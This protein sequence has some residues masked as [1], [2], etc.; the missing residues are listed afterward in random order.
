[1]ENKPVLVDNWVCTQPHGGTQPKIGA[2]TVACPVPMGAIWIHV[3]DDDG[4]DVPGISAIAVKTEKVTKAGFA[5]WD[6]LPADTYEVQ[7]VK[8]SEDFLPLAVDTAEN[9]QVRRG[10]ITSVQFMLERALQMKVIVKVG[11]KPASIEDIQVDVTGKYPTDKQDGKTVKDVGAT[12]SKLHK[13]SY[14]AT[15]TLNE[16][17]K[18][19]YWID[20]DATKPCEVA[21]RKPN[22]VVFTLQLIVV[23]K[24]SFHVQEKIAG[25]FEEL[26]GARVKLKEPDVEKSTALQ[27]TKAIAEFEVKVASR[28]PKTTVEVVSL[29]PDDKDEDVYEVISLVTV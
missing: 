2:A 5:S 10:E 24:V 18:K 26:A 8:L 4:E 28:E 11:D 7:V 19:K 17:Q 9:V 6:P 13:G 14:T 12:F 21:Y 20:G 22:E 16:E 25:K 23:L 29:M 3:I 15:I 27:D 1:M